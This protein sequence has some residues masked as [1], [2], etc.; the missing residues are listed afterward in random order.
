VGQSSLASGE[1]LLGTR[2]IVLK[3]IAGYDIDGADLTGSSDP[4]CLPL[5]YLPRSPHRFFLTV[6]RT[7]FET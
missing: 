3:L 4:V 2:V 1:L 6:F 7:I 5:V